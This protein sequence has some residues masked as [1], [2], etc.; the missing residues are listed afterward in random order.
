[1]FDGRSLHLFDQLRSSR[2]ERSSPFPIA[3][4]LGQKK[5]D[6][7]VQPPSWSADQSVDRRMFRCAEVSSRAM[8]ASRSD[9][10]TST[11]A[12]NGVC[13]QNAA[14]CWY[15]DQSADRSVHR[16][17]FRYAGFPNRAMET[18][19]S[20]ALATAIAINAVRK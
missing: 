9:A 6:K 19:R 16:H 20:D 14:A 13:K 17:M 3:P 15:A 5:Q 1:M 11:I 18:S 2:R 12:I 10:L 7:L 4:R 8:E